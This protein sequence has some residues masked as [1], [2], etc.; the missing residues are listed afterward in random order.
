MKFPD[1]LLGITFNV[2]PP[3]SRSR[4]PISLISG[5]QM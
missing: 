4:D 1:G 5:L 3:S 2:P